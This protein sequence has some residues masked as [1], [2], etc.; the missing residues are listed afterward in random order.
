MIFALD[1]FYACWSD[2]ARGR[3][4][5]RCATAANP[6][7]LQRALFWGLYALVYLAG[8]RCR[9]RWRAC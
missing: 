7:R 4:H 8:E 2:A 6:R 9:R 5:E 3:R 1:Y